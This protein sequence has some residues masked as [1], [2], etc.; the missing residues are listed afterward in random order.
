MYLYSY[1]CNLYGINEEFNPV[2]KK[3]ELTMMLQTA[4][5]ENSGDYRFFLFFQLAEIVPVN[6]TKFVLDSGV[7]Q[8]FDTFNFTSGNLY[9]STF[10]WSF[11]IR[12][13]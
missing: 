9:K 4:I 11:V 2:K 6:L 12:V 10:R 13:L 1:H 8:V 7:L 5:N 3:N